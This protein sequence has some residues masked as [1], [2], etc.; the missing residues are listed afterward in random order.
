[1]F[2]LRPNG[3]CEAEAVMLVLA[4]EKPCWICQRKARKGTAYMC[5]SC[6]WHYQ[7]KDYH[8]VYHYML[9]AAHVEHGV[10]NKYNYGLGCLRCNNFYGMFGPTEFA[11]NPNSRKDG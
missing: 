7:R 3:E 5:A 1:M 11:A 8:A 4:G 6:R 9:R 10:A 2:S